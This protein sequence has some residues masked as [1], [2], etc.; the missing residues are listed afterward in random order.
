VKKKDQFLLSEQDIVTIAKNNHFSTSWNLNLRKNNNTMSPLSTS[1]Q[2]Q[3]QISISCQKIID[4]ADILGDSVLK[5]ISQYCFQLKS[6]DLSFCHRITDV[7]LISLAEN[8][9]LL[10]RV[11]FE[12]CPLISDT[13]IETLLKTNPRLQQINLN[14]CRNIG[15][16]TL[17]ALA[18][19]CPSL[20]Q[21]DIAFCILI[22]NDGLSQFAT[23]KSE[24]S[25]RLIRHLNISNCRRISDEGIV[26][27]VKKCTRLTSL[28]VHFC[29][30]LTDVGISMV[31][32]QCLELENLNLEEVRL[33]T[34]KIFMFDQ[35]KD[36]RALV[37]KNLLKQLTSLVLSG[38]NSLNDLA[39][40]HL[41]H[42]ARKIKTISLSSCENITDQGIQS[43]I[44]DA[45]DHSKTGTCLEE[46]DF[47]YCPQLTCQG[48]HRVVSRCP[49]LISLDL[50]GC[51]HLKDKELMEILQSC[52]KILKLK[53][54]FCRDLTDEVLKTIAGTLWLEELNLS[55]CVKITDEGLIAIISQFTNLEHL[56]IAACTRLSIQTL[57]SLAE[58]SLQLKSLDISHCGS[59][60]RPLPVAGLGW[61]SD[62]K[63]TEK[64]VDLLKELQMKRQVKI[65]YSKMDDIYENLEMQR[66]KNDPHKEQKVL[67]DNREEEEDTQDNEDKEEN[68]NVSMDKKIKKKKDMKKK[69]L[70]HELIYG[71]NG[72]STPTKTSSTIRN[73]TYPTSLPP[74]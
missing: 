4:Q 29:D 24:D 40:G 11:A 21:I 8:I 9:H 32:H 28:N 46:L 61:I 22:S 59:L 43:L 51:I 66:Y 30:K 74:L 55:R 57:E 31:L 60:L 70:L 63:S 45:F 14:A 65:V 53:L 23:L 25:A 18:R 2:Q 47:S 33:V 72:G 10:E 54:A 71:I 38:C 36:G 17:I 12:A 1:Q 73:A 69:K 16:R 37:D 50:S 26:L 41:G 35:E 58:H 13:G 27:F 6:L 19:H 20:T 68:Q 64:A 52:T 39:L 5:G 62:V 48:I 56:N 34:H 15:D 67:Q 42:R 7:A 49:K 44:E 3:E